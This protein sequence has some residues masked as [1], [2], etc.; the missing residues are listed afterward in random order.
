MFDHLS[1]EVNSPPETK[2]EKEIKTFRSAGLY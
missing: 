1:K 2:R